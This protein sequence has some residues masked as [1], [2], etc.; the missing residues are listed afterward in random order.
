M[1]KSKEST[2]ADEENVDVDREPGTKTF[3]DKLE[4]FLSG[5][6]ANDS[7]PKTAKQPIAGEDGSFVNEKDPD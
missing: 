3:D 2:A 7:N 5:S 6:N 1:N 4:D